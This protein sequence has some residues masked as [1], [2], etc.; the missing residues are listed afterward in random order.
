M[1]TPEPISWL[2]WTGG[3]HVGK[4]RKNNED[5]F[6]ALTFNARDV[7]FL[8]KIGEA[9]LA[10]DDFI[11]AVSDGMGGAQAGEFAS[12]ITV[13]KLTKLMPRAY[14]S[15]LA[16]IEVGFSDLFQ[17][18]FSEIHRALAYLGDTYEECRGMGATLSLAWFTPGWMY[19]AHIGDSRIYYL[20]A[21]GGMKQLTHDHSHVGWLLRTG[22]INEREARTH[23]ARNSLQMALG[24]GHQFIDPHVGSV[25]LEPG[26]LFLLCS[27]GIIDGLWDKNILQLLRE[28]SPAEATLPPAQRLLEAAL[29]RSGKDN[30]TA[31][32]VE[33]HPEASS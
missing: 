22:R 16:G 31:V 20:P 24:A 12:R 21:G 26:D 6:L 1:Q 11:F 30:L 13:D 15:G 14:R 9:P 33:V 7:Q 3:T 18:L 27:D 5:A 10:S 8:G 28:P 2:R 17:E 4:I 23:P 19:F 25:G 29:E 32:V